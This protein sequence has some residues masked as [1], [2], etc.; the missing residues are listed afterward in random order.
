MKL[1][2]TYELLHDDFSIIAFHDAKVKNFEELDEKLEGIIEEHWG[3][4]ELPFPILLDATGQTLRDY[5]IRSFP[6]LLLIDPDGK[7]V[8][9]NAEEML[10]EILGKMAKER[11]LKIEEDA[12]GP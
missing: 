9:G 8:K 7:L 4:R 11:G 3:G 12:D 1:W 6:T 10:E 2:D 5:G